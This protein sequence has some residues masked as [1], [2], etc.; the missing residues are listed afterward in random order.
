VKF[1][2]TLSVTLPL[3]LLTFSASLTLLSHW[4]QTN[5]LENEA[6]Q[7][8]RQVG[9]YLGSAL[10]GP[11]QDHVLE[12]HHALAQREL[13]RQATRQDIALSV[14]ADAQGRISQ[15]SDFRLRG[16]LL[17][18]LEDTPPQE[19]LDRAL[20]TLSAQ[21]W[22]AAERDVIWGIYPI[23][24]PPASGMLRAQQPLLLLVK[25]DG[26]AQREQA[27]YRLRRD[28]GFLIAGSALLTLLLWLYLRSTVSRRIQQLSRSLEGF[29]A[30]ETAQPP[31]IGGEDEIAQLA[32]HFG[33]LAASLTQRNSLLQLEARTREATEQ[34]LRDSE[35]RYRTLVNKLPHRVFVKDRAS[36]YLACNERYAQDLGLP[37]EAI[38]GRDDY[39][40]F[41]PDLAAKYQ[42]DDQ[43][44]MSSGESAEIEERY[45][46]Q[47]RELWIRTI[48]TPL[49]DDSGEVTAVLGIFEDITARRQDEES[50]R[51][52]A[53]V[54]ENSLDSVLITDASRSIIAV[55]PAFER[56]TGYPA[57]EALGKTPRLLRSGLHDEGFYQEMY[58]RL[59][60]TDH[61]QGEIW[62]RRKDGTAYVEL[63][64]ISAVRNQAGEI[65]H[66]VGVST[67]IQ[68]LKDTQH[69]L[70]QL[71]HYDALTTLPNRTLLSDRLMQAQAQADRHQQ[72]LAVCF[73]DLDG[74]KPINDHHGH[75]T[76][77][78]LL[79]EV[80]NRL[81]QA[82]RAGD[83]VARLGGDEFVLLL[84][85]FQQIAELEQV[86]GRI[87]AETAAPYLVSGKELHVSASIG[88]TIYPFDNSDADTLL[89]HADQAM[90]Q[91]KQAGRNCH[92]MFDAERDRQSKARQEELDQIRSAL[93]RGELVLHYQPKV[94]L[95]SGRVVG[96]EALI[97][98]QD[99]QRGL[100]P[101]L[102]FL[103]L[104]EGSDLIIEIGDWVLDTTLAQMAAWKA[105]GL[106]L[107]V[108]I[109]I[110]ARHL[111][112]GYFV[113]RLQESLQRHL[114]VPPSWLELEILE[115]TALQDLSHARDVI[116]ACRQLGVHFALDDFGTGYS[117]LSYLKN[118]PADVIKIDRSF[119]QDILEDADDLALVEG[120][121][122][123]ATAFNRTVIAE[124]METGE[125]G[126]LLLR[127]GCDIAQGFGIAR[128]MP[129]ADMPAWLAAYR[130]DPRWQ[131]WADVIWEM[132]DFPLLLAQQDHLRWVRRVTHFLEGKSLALS[133]SELTDQHA[134]RFG[135]WYY[136]RGRSRYGHMREYAEVEAIHDEVHR[137]GPEIVRLY[138]GG[139][140]AGAQQRVPE[141]L[142]LKDAILDKLATL[143]RAVAGRLSKDD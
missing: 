39:A 140:L 68:S 19:K 24:Q 101:P 81:K 121:V 74:F 94:N 86:L 47:D 102:E 1:R 64:N 132:A 8:L 137:I 22:P 70:E 77:D 122:G 51:L 114:E 65:S 119:V 53:S 105:M 58:Q 69:R 49:R 3:L 143:Q 130:P 85:D 23:S 73:L 18:Q 9:A 113:Q 59:T 100:V 31:D 30:D 45:L 88:V 62:N 17:S 84:N 56:M 108:S 131:L 48:K 87:Q 99:P 112:Q 57:A 90:Y 98:W 134:C 72:L 92:Q 37:E 76:G 123:L 20:R 34:A 83:T 96:A 126:L 36:R 55:N 120:V 111:Q 129:A 33:Q 125:H 128:P 97:R 109:N 42:S 79:L 14:L 21:L 40:F 52:A 46:H 93:Q 78:R 7:H 95:R 89:R 41:P 15:S 106:T 43:R 2:Y 6:R 32:R 27:E 63:L 4:I 82:V 115:S 141:L 29:V 116:G 16:S 80:A 66:Y 110:A 50:L 104:A 139:D 117:S 12:G 133:E 26:S 138:Q 28:T 71:A 142:R 91:A 60:D 67:D 107:P 103:P 44:V 75:A 5:E 136:G 38:L 135:Q 35:S 54:F 127:L 118:I 11:V 10:A 124:G 13:E 61:W 25:L